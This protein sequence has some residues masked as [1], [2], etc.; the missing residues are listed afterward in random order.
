MHL[1]SLL[2]ILGSRPL[3]D[4]VQRPFIADIGCGPATV[5]LALAQRYRLRHP[6]ERMACRYV[7]LDA[8]PHMHG[9]A[10]RYLAH[11]SLF[12]D[13]RCLFVE[14]FGVFRERIDGVNRLIDSSTHAL[15]ALS[16]VL[17][18]P[19]L[20]PDFGEVVARLVLALARIEDFPVFVI[21][22][23]ISAGPY[24]AE[25][26]FFDTLSAAG[27][28][29]EGASGSLTQVYAPRNQR[30]EVVATNNAPPAGN[31]FWKYGQ[32]IQI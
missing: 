17:R 24:K 4:G 1:A 28:T 12:A 31:V 30:G 16:Y 14:N 25:R 21:L 8:S 3:F 9:I 27:Y 22:Q 6:E 7:G 20:P 23:D 5:A 19:A 18:Q 2:T 32:V 13:V 10:Q 29:I 15:V 26:L 11:P